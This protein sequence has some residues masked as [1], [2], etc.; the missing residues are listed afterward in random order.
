MRRALALEGLSLPATNQAWADLIASAQ[1]GA[2]GGEIADSLWLRDG[3][4]FNPAFL[5][6]ARAF[7]AAG[8]LPLP[9][10]HTKAAA[11]VNG[12]VDSARPA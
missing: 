6:A 1:A 8:T 11:A 10:D 3:V 4:A 2:A 5:A 12:W 7:F 9:A